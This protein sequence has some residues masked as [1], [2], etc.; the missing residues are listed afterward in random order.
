VDVSVRNQ[1]QLI[2]YADRLAR[3]LPGLTALLTGPLE[4]LFGGVHVLPFFDPIDGADAG[5]DPVDHR[6]VDPRIGT[7]DDVDALGRELPVMADLIVNHVA[8]GSPQ[9]QDFLAKGED[10]EHAGMFLTLDKVFPDGVTEAGLTSIYRPRP[11]LPL[12]PVQL[13]DR[14]RRIVWTTFTPNQIDIDVRDPAG[15]RY[16]EE[17]LD[18]FA[19]NGIRV[20]RMDAIGYA[21]KTPG[22]SSFMT[23]D[24]FAFIDE[25]T[26]RAHERDIEVLVEVH[27]Y[28]QKQVEIARQVDWVY[29]FA[30]PPLILHGLYTGNAER[31]RRWFEIRPRNAVTVLDT[32]DGI[33]VIDVGP[34]TSNVAHLGL[35]DAEEID[36]LVEGIHEHSHGTSRLA[37]GTAASNVD[38]YQVNCTYFDALGAQDDAYLIA[39]LLQLWI[40]GVPQV[41][42]VGLLAGHNDVELLHASG[43][44]RD[45]NRHRYTELEV[46]VALHRP[47]VRRLAALLRLRNTHPAFGGSWE[48][49][50]EGQGEGVLA[51]R[52]TD[53]DGALAELRVDLRARTY[54]VTLSDDGS[55]RTVT[56]LA[57][58]AG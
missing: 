50:D 21:V 9:F 13:G 1:V 41:Y 34:D 10:S 3:D 53:D 49:L 7:W 44:G 20:V 51:Q 45:I 39:R 38:I 30:L 26:A 47:V 14:S 33:G 54:E 17:I 56:D 6:E 52:W 36:E 35:L 46:E 42:Y 15:R 12:T 43:V 22:T 18:R 4:G 23:E 5:F 2:T 29:D 40:P 57:D 24:T 31:L 48:L 11:G 37:T 19:A 16:L 8:A 58:L 25:L 55:T 28:W 27:S 32:H